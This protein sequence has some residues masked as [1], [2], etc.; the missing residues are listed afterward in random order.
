MNVLTVIFESPRQINYF[1]N[2]ISNCSKKF[3]CK[4]K[5]VKD[6]SINSASL[7]SMLRIGINV[8]FDIVI[9]S[10]DGNNIEN[11]KKYKEEIERW[12]V[13]YGNDNEN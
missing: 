4:L 7:L 6:N 13:N 12:F 5:I 8:P 11:I 3:R 2:E 9:E 10:Y 1:Y